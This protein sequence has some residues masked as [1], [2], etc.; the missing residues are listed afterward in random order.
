MQVDPVPPD[1]RPQIS[2]TPS[3]GLNLP[4]DVL[5]RQVEFRT[6]LVEGATAFKTADIEPLFGPVLN[7]HVKFA[8]VVAAINR[9]TALYDKGGYVFYSVTLPQQDLGSDRLRI[10]VIEAAVAKVEIDPAIATGKARARIDEALAPL[11]GRRPLRKAEL[12]RRLLLAADTPGTALTASAKPTAD[13]PTKVDLVIGGTFERFQPIA[14]LD[15]F[16]TTP[17]TSV[18]F[19]GRRHRPLAAHRRRPAGVALPVRVA[20]EQPEPVRCALQPAG[21]HRRQSLRPARPGGLAASAGHHQTASRSTTL[22]S[23]CS[24]ACTTP[25]RSCARSTG[26]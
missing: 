18:N 6:I 1:R 17:N 7:R 16:Q 14:Q 5:D 2:V 20:L 3:L 21:R 24:A 11:I 22:R 12:E 25:I 26:P 8:E 15:D 19:R 4:P 13:D 10:I 23:P 9:I